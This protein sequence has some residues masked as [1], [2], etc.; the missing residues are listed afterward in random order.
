MQRTFQLQPVQSETGDAFGGRVGV[1]APPGPGA[2]QP[3]G[4]RPNDVVLFQHHFA[5]RDAWLRERI[6]DCKPSAVAVA[7]YGIEC[8]RLATDAGKR[9]RPTGPPP[10]FVASRQPMVVTTTRTIWAREKRIRLHSN[11]IPAVDRHSYPGKVVL[12]RRC[13]C[14]GNKAD[15]LSLAHLWIR[16]SHG[17][18]LVAPN[19]FWLWNSAEQGDRRTSGSRLDVRLPAQRADHSPLFSGIKFL[20]TRFMC[21]RLQS[22]P[23]CILRNLVEF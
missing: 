13:I 21:H 19:Y 10:R 2:H 16:W 14:P 3:S 23:N 7:R 11:L 22:H 6:I 8:D 20:R 18:G 15:C 4:I 1:A 17:Y 12:G 5:L 9:Q